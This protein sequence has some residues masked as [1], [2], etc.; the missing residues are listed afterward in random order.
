VALVGSGGGAQVDV[1]EGVR[2]DLD[3]AAGDQALQ[4]V[5]A[6]LGLAGELAAVVMCLLGGGPVA[7]VAVDDQVD[8]RPGVIFLEQRQ[9]IVQVVGVAVVEGDGDAFRRQR[10]PLLPQLAEGEE[11]PALALQPGELGLEV[12]RGDAQAIEAGARSVRA[13][14]VVH[15]HARPLPIHWRTPPGVAVGEPCRDGKRAE[16]ESE[17]H[18][19]VP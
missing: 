12:F 10:V 18:A 11:A 2:A 15:E 13:D 1:A 17:G 9:G 7:L 14:H 16:D 19:S 5:V 4:F 3:A 8:G 6:Q